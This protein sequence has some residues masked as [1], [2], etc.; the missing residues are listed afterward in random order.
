[1]NI[2][3]VVRPRLD[4]DSEAVDYIRA[5]TS[6]ENNDMVLGFQSMKYYRVTLIICSGEYKL[7][8]LAKL[9][10]TN[11]PWRVSNESRSPA[12]RV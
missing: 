9:A 2:F 3:V 10:S 1:M 5:S 4:G 6:K 7:K 11:L 12:W 8:S